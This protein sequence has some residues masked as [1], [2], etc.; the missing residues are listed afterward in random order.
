MG[1]SCLARRLWM[2]GFFI[3]LHHTQ[4]TRSSVCC[5][6][7]VCT[8]PPLCCDEEQ[9]VN[10]STVVFDVKVVTSLEDG[11][12]VQ[13]NVSWARPPGHDFDGYAVEVDYDRISY[14]ISCDI[15]N[16]GY[17]TTRT[18]SIYLKD[19]PFG[20]DVKIYVYSANLTAMVRNGKRSTLRVIELPDCFESTQ[21]LQFCQTKV[22]PILSKP[23]GLR[24]DNITTRVDT[25]KGTP[26]GMFNVFWHPPAQ[27]PVDRMIGQFEVVVIR[28]DS[29]FKT[30]TSELVVPAP[31]QMMYTN[32]FDVSFEHSFQIDVPSNWT[33]VIEIRVQGFLNSGNK[34]CRSNSLQCTGRTAVLLQH[35]NITKDTPKAHLPPDDFW[36]IVASC[37]AGALVVLFV[38]ICFI[39]LWRK[40]SG[41]TSVKDTRRSERFSKKEFDRSLLRGSTEIGRGSFGVVYKAVAFGSLKG[42]AGFYPVAVKSIKEFMKY[43]DLLH[44][45]WKSRE[46]KSAEEDSIYKVTEKSKLQIARQIARG[47][48]YISMTRYYHGDLAARN[49]L[50]GA[51]L[52]IKVSDFGLAA[53]IYARGYKRLEPD[54]KRPM[55]WVSLETNLTGKCTIEADVWSFGIVLYEIFT[56]GDAPYQGVQNAE[57]LPKLKRGYR[58]DQP[59]GCPLEVY[60]IMRQCWLEYPLLRPSFTKLS[61]LLDELLAKD[62]DYMDLDGAAASMDG[63]KPETVQSNE[64]SNLSGEPDELNLWLHITGEVP[65]SVR[66]L[67][68][69]PFTADGTLSD[70][71]G[72][73][74]EMKDIQFDRF[75]D[76]DKMTLTE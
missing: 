27:I 61:E 8:A 38:V 2:I 17:K 53:D 26:V 47:M 52:Q 50:V 65:E 51:N 66:T 64:L 1:L 39:C 71:S 4:S 30:F 33:E 19:L 13:A 41:I 3:L 67:D 24:V 49:V 15:K 69:V 75:R 55:K 72:Q 40:R 76:S 57:L 29:Q 20:Y 56:L 60:D 59:E 70:D 46:S 18:E 34:S 11:W 54:E 36:I 5:T 10:S 22:V 58:L 23:I 31:S 9:R 21:D 42:I 44:F 14:G 63:V 43:G 7:D 73:F 32:P 68:F 6:P 28:S 16:P 62:S 48:E 35:V 37:S 12:S 74:M 25:T 45:M